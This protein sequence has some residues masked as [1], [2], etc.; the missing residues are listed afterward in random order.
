MKRTRHKVSRRIRGA[1]IIDALLGVFVL[2]LGAAAFFSLY[3]LFVRSKAIGQ[4]QST[5]LQLANRM[6]EHIQLL[7]ASDLNPATLTALNLV[8]AGSSGTPYSFSNIPLDEASGYSPSRALPNGAGTM[9]VEDVDNNSKLVTIE[10]TWR[11]PN[12]EE[13]SIRTGT[14]VGGFR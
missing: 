7:K 9:E 5:A 14:V 12:G 13:Q 4:N 1:I 3:P 11:N 8:D 10:L 6:V 2:A